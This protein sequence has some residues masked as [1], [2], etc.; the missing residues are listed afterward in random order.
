MAALARAYGLNPNVSELKLRG[1]RRQP[2]EVATFFASAARIRPP[3]VNFD[4][5]EFVF[6]LNFCGL[7]GQ[8]RALTGIW[9]PDLA[10]EGMK[11]ITASV[12]HLF[13]RCQL[14]TFGAAEYLAKM[15]H[16]IRWL[17]CRFGK[18]GVY[19]LTRSIPSLFVGSPTFEEHFAS[20][21]M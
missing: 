21:D 3:D 20:Y 7:K 5:E 6:S 17:G 11:H 14:G 19:V 12:A 18:D 16:L 1:N 4:P 2:A 15:P 10:D 8:F 13:V 9:L